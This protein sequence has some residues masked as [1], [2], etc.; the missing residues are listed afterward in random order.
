MTT[1]PRPF[2]PRRPTRR[3]VRPNAGGDSVLSDPAD[4]SEWLKLALAQHYRNLQELDARAAQNGPLDVPLQLTNK[5]AA[6]KEQIAQLERRLLGRSDKPSP[7]EQLFSAGM[8]AYLQGNPDE[9]R[10]LLKLSLKAEPF[11]ARA[12]QLLE[13]MEHQAGEGDGRRW[14]AIRGRRSF[15]ILIGTGLA[16]LAVIGGLVA[17]RGW[18]LEDKATPGTTITA[19]AQGVTG[20]TQA[21]GTENA[22]VGATT[23]ALAPELEA[24]E[25]TEAVAAAGA[26]EILLRCWPNCADISLH[27][28][29]LREAKLS[30]AKLNGAELRGADLS[31]ANLSGADL[32]GA[33]LRRANLRRANLSRTNLS[34]ANLSGADLSGA[35]LSGADLS[36]ADLWWSD[37]RDSQVNE[38][39]QIEAKWRL[40]WEIVNKGASQ[41]N[42]RWADLRWTDLRNVNLREA[43]L[44][45][46]DLSV[47]NLSGADL[48]GAD[49][50][51]A[52]LWWTDLKDSQIDETTQ[53]EAKWR[54]VWEIANKRALQHNLIGADLRGANLSETDLSGSNL[55]G[56]NLSWADLSGANLSEADL[57]KTNLNKADLSETRY[58]E[59]TRWPAGFDPAAA[60][61]VRE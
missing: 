38:T 18:Y 6:E 1:L 12:E 20:T 50:S 45:G 2:G 27:D 39:T 29:D 54:L 23:T 19:M 43:D 37:L 13:E 21:E 17:Y 9:A 32:K 7:V 57:S 59:G 10:R 15:G 4:G 56:T 53:I 3:S 48:R 16:A 24:T 28:A 31:G 52:N 49:L 58:N 22:Q 51:R 34:W 14:R 8:R 42:L 41:H 46:A 36:R 55:S 40:V 44:R 26:I 30:L 35:D 11:Y 60:G 5:I 47:A 33:N 61:A 25:A